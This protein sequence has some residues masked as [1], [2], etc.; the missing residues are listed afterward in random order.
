[1]PEDET[2]NKVYAKVKR[3]TMHFVKNRETRD[4]NIDETEKSNPAPCPED[5]FFNL[6][7][8]VLRVVYLGLLL[9]VCAIG[10]IK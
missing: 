6:G 3:F 1:M 5:P 10:K 4:R 8:Q 9:F 2:I 7:F